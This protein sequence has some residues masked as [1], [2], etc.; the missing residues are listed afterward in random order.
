MNISYDA[1]IG[2]SQINVEVRFKW[3]RY[4]GDALLQNINYTR[5]HF[6]NLF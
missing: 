6:V 3:L 1:N 5:L 2:P 4:N